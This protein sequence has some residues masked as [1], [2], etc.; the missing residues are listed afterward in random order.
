MALVYTEGKSVVFFFNCHADTVHA[1]AECSLP[2]C[3]VSEVHT[4]EH[5]LSED[6]L[7][8]NLNWIHHSAPKACS[9][10]HL[11]QASSEQPV[12]PND[13]ETSVSSLLQECKDVFDE[14]VPPA[15]SG[16]PFKINQLGNFS[17]ELTEI[18]V[19]FCPLLTK[20]AVF[21]WLPEHD[22]AFVEAKSR[23]STTPVLTSFGVD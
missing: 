5:P 11:L 14:T 2:D 18:M 7:L 16:E 20:D 4:Q 19:P 17:K 6:E 9:Q 21:Q 22:H 15:M 13:D 3:S 10:V 1:P 23:L 8:S 12:V